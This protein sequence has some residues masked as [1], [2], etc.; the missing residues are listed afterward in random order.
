M[1]K[2]AKTLDDL[3]LATLPKMPRSYG[4]RKD[5]RPLAD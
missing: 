3:L 4:E 5:S 2:E 1:A